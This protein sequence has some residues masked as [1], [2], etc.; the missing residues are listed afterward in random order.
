MHPRLLDVWWSKNRGWWEK[1]NEKKRRLKN[2]SNYRCLLEERISPKKDGNVWRSE[3][4]MW[5]QIIKMFIPWDFFLCDI[6]WWFTS[7]TWDILLYYPF[8]A[9]LGYQI[10]ESKIIRAGL[11]L[12]HSCFMWMLLCVPSV[13]ERCG[14]RIE[15]DKNFIHLFMLYTFLE[16]FPAR[17]L[18]LKV[19]TLTVL[20][21]LCVWLSFLKYKYSKILDAL[22]CKQEEA[23]NLNYQ[24]HALSSL[25]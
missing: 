3:L 22:R 13:Y 19:E 8:S 12:R 24:P 16:H 5:P 10:Y 2:G 23:V 21:I 18:K 17:V 14:Q 7:E 11:M 25:L 6:I 20:L 4:K 1:G 9:Y 15:L